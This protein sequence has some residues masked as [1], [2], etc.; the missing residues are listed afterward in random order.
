MNGN[1]NFDIKKGALVSYDAVKSIGKFAFPFRNLDNI[2]FDN[3]NGKFDIKGRL[4]TINPMMINSS[5]LNM[6]LA[7]VYATTGKGTNIFLDVPLRN[8]KK[9]E[10]ITDKQEIRE[11]R[12]KGIL[13]YTSSPQ[14][15][16][17][18]KLSLNWLVKKIKRVKVAGFQIYLRL[19]R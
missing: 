10:D 17:M 18:V 9:D 13:S 19:E 16:R 6:D 7:G 5:V 11:R 4:V 3:L 2:T 14:M 1:V 8:P 12:M 15:E